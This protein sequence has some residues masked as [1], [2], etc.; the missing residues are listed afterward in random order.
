VIAALPLVIWN[1]AMK[2]PVPFLSCNDLQMAGLAAMSL[3]FIAEATAMVLIIFYLVVLAGLFPMPKLVKPLAGLVWFVLTGGFLT[4]VLLAVGIYTATWQ[5]QQSFIPQIKLSDHFDYNYGFSFA[6]I[7]YVCSLLMFFVTLLV[8]SKD[9]V[10]RSTQPA[11]SPNLV[12]VL[13]MVVAGVV[14]GIAVA[15]AGA[16]GIMA[17][18]GIFDAEPMGDS[19][20]NPCA[21]QKWKDLGPGDHY[22]DNTDCFKNGVVAVLEQA[23]ANVTKGY[24]GLMDVGERKPISVPYS[25]TALCP[26]NVHWHLG[27]E[28]LSV[29]Q[30][31]DKGKGPKD[32]GNDLSYEGTSRRQLDGRR[33]EQSKKRLG[34]QCMYYD[35][36][37]QRFND[38]LYKWETCE[39]MLVGETYEIH[40]PHSAAG[41]CGTKWQYQTPF[42]D[43]VFCRDDVIS[44]VP[45]NTY[46]NIG[47]Q[48]QIFTVINDDRDEYSFDNL[49]AGMIVDANKQNGMGI[50][51]AYY[52]GSTTG[53]TRNN[54]M[55][56][57][58]TPITW[59]VDRKCHLVS[60][61]SFDKLCKDMMAISKD[62]GGDD[63]HDDLHPHG[64]RETVLDELAANNQFRRSRD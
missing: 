15:G 57:R 14:V 21:G 10:A 38:T 13:V 2:H 32:G 4:V 48:G 23:G 52:T 47:V 11:S 44:V 3:G 43:G 54:V 7:G 19:S 16:V 63:M 40:W 17:G 27:A 1:D 36:S 41:A 58:Y 42:Y 35:A 28:H 26:V 49:I 46:E 24:Q 8:L 51:I 37:D 50:D 29:G 30:Y 61:K 5:C 20:V 12:K 34:H 59:Q 6:I 33:L 31:D 45:L 56:S 39:K 55:C 60:A 53:T 64:A 62:L 25:E 9:G 22:F 18:N